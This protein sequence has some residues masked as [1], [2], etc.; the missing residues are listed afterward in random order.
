MPSS[1]SNEQQDEQI[2]QPLHKPLHH[3]R[4]TQQR[5]P[6]WRP[7]L[8][9]FGAI[10]M[11]IISCLI[12]LALGLLFF[13]LQNGYNEVRVRYDDKCTEYNQLCEVEFDV[14]EDMSGYLEMRYELTK[15][16]QNHRRFGFS[17]ID[18]QLAGDYVDFDGM[19]NCKPY[20]SHND[21]SDPSQWILP[22]GL[23]ALS[24]FNDTYTVTHNDGSAIPA[25]TEEGIA[26]PSERDYLYKPLNERYTDGDKWL[27][28]LSDIFPGGMTNEHF[29]VWMRQSA[30]PHLVKTYSIC[31]DCEIPSGR[32]T[33]RV[34]NR[35][36]TTSFN[37]EKYFV[38]AKV[39][40]LGTH[41]IYLGVVYM[42]CGGICGIY[43]LVLLISEMLC[44][45]K[46]GE[47]RK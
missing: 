2:I 29:M 23:F 27:D 45:R 46:M 28:A 1:S 36:P 12:L 9:T 20:R 31:E 43:A 41:N 25:F 14:E 37:G 4:F 3:Y 11:L 19:S 26:Y 24:V 17:R 30:L 47:Y 8:T 44:P 13:F 21:S 32:Y 16:H 22:C 40:T 18:E 5:L 10:L 38:I 7:V 34:F 39:T 35:Y 33:L 15:F 6:G 42:V